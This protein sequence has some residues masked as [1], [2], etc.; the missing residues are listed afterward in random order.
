MSMFNDLQVFDGLCCA[1]QYHE[2]YRRNAHLTFN[3]RTKTTLSF[4][5]NTIMDGKNSSE[6]ESAREAAFK[7]DQSLVEFPF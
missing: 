2:F 3:N 5:N 6:I 7:Y 1:F 4:L